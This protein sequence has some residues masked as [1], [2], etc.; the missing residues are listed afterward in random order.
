MLFAALLL[1]SCAGGAPDIVLDETEVDLGEVINGEVVTLEV[2]VRNSGSEALVIEAVTTSCGCTSAEVQPASIAP[3]SEGLLLIRYD[4]GAHG[5]E[6]N[7]PVMRQIFIASNDP[8]LPEA[9]FRIFVD[10]IPPES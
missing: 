2:T 7:G 3:G 9:E 5:P 10:V 6:A 8:D 4:S 1:A